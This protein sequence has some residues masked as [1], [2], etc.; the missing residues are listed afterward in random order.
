MPRVNKTLAHLS[1]L[2]ALLLVSACAS[3]SYGPVEQYFEPER[4]IAN[5]YG[6]AQPDG[7]TTLRLMTL[8]TA[9]GRGTGFHQFFTPSRKIK[10]NLD[11]IASLIRREQPDIIALQ[12]TDSVSGWSGTFNHVEYLLYRTG[13]LVSYQGLH[14]QSMNLQ[15]GTALL[16]KTPLRNRQSLVFEKSSIP[17]P[18]GFVIASVTW[19][20][21][22]DRQIDVVSVHLDFLAGRYRRSQAETLV[23]ELVIRNRPVILMGDLNTEWA[24]RDGVMDY[25]VEALNLSVYRPESEDIITFPST[26]RRLD[27]IL[28][29]SEFELVDHKVLMDDLSDHRAVIA[30]IRLVTD[31]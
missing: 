29:S 5:E 1:L 19:P 20:D 21:N 12:E 9:H 23:N 10:D 8:N 24:H 17:L 31:D 15:Y 30:D 27:W 22:P 7:L 26:G 16:A 18:K 25:L 14:V 28:V 2:A 6:T 13:Y 3:V 11:T 4:K